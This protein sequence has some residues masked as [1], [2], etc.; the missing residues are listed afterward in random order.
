MFE[1]LTAYPH[2]KGVIL[3]LPNVTALIKIPDD[4]IDRLEL[5]SADFFDQWPSL[6][7]DCV[8]LSRVLHDWSDEN[9]IEIL[10]KIY[11]V[12]PDS[13]SRL[14]IIENI[15]G[16]SLLDLN[17]L[18]MTEGKERTLSGFEKILT[19]SGFVLESTCPLNE[20]STILIA[21]K[22]NE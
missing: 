8:L 2:L 19:E 10:K 9:S 3:D 21:R 14:Y 11:F 20:V 1:L 5:I 18:V 22:N 12:L 13:A 4:F 15:C 6:K 17:M 7:A 16:G